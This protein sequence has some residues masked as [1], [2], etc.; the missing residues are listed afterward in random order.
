MKGH[1]FVS[2]FMT[3]LNP[4]IVCYFNDLFAKEAKEL[5]IWLCGKMK[6]GD[7]EISRSGNSQTVF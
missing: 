2:F 1:A 7:N 4:V 6:M 5:Y 3:A